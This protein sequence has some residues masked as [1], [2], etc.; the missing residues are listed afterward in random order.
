M[1]VDPAPLD[2]LERALVA[3]RPHLVG[4][5]Y[6]ITGS[7]VEAEDIVQE[8][9]LRAR[10]ADPAAV[11][12]PEAWLT[13]VVS[14]LALDSLK[15]ARVRREAYVGPYLPE[16]VPTGG[17]RAGLAG[18]AG[19]DD[20]DPEG[21]AERAE[22][23]TFG[24]LRVLDTLGPVERVVFLLADVFDLPYAQI[25]EVVGRSPEACRQVASRARR[26]VRA[27]RPAHAP[28]AEAQAV[29]DELLAA[30]AAADVDRL[31]ALLGEDVVLISD[32]G[33]VVRAAR[34]PV[35]GPDRVGRFLAW[36]ARRYGEHP[37]D[38]EARPLNGEPGLVI[39]YGGEPLVT[40]AFGVVGGRVAT[41]H[42]VRNPDKLAG[43]D[44][45]APVV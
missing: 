43:L 14:R 8:A 44:I 39:R 36:L 35:V 13:T 31:V 10:R 9:W 34:R 23:L 40:M 4:V 33:P 37:V 19:A 38:V 27:E 20:G 30:F 16:P 17:A 22:S 1:A 2:R 6:R 21:M 24:F 5:A 3:E 41:I 26:R 11:E 42:I 32:G 25:A 45:D 29:A 28:P 15:S 7:R 12:N 18:P